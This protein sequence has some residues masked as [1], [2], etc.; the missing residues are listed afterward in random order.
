LRS[1]L[2]ACAPIAGIAFLRVLNQRLS[3]ILLSLLGGA[4][5]TGFFSAGARIAEAARIGH[6]AVL[7]ALFP[8]MSE[9]S[10]A[11]QADV[12]SR[13][14]RPFWWLVA[15]AGAGSLLIFASA[16]LLIEVAYGAPFRPALG[17]LRILAFVLV[18]F[19]I[20]DYFSIAFISQNREALM[21]RITAAYLVTLVAL[22]ALLVPGRGQ[23]GAAWALLVAELLQAAALISSWKL[24]PVAGSI[25]VEL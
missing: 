7:S 4:A 9:A 10:G 1:L 25:P 13:Y 20:N 15:A 3:L 2:A 5:A 17:A 14:R 22:M 16:P 12:A 23:E 24:N 11:G 8:M 6:H 19:T 21:M 18:P